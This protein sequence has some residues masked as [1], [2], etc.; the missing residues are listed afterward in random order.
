MAKTSSAKSN[1]RIRKGAVINAPVTPAKPKMTSGGRALWKGSIN[2]G[3]VCV[4]VA[5]YSSVRDFKFSGKLFRSGDLSP[6]NYKKIAETDGKEVTADQ[7][8]KGY[9]FI[10]DKG[11]TRI[12]TLN[13]QELASI[14]LPSL[15]NIDID[16]FVSAKEVDNILLAKSYFIRADKGGA[17][18][19]AIIFAALRKSG[20][21]GIAKVALRNREYLAVVRPN[22]SHP[23]QNLLQLDVLHFAPEMVSPDF[24]DGADLK[25]VSKDELTFATMLV[26]QMTRTF[27]LENYTN[28]YVDAMGELIAKK[29][30]GTLTTTPTEAPVAREVPDIL[31]VLRRS[32]AQKA[33]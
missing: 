4:P 30:A 19:Y 14:N 26:D 11:E 5:I 15:R 20:K 23:G 32:V 9:D 29:A 1:V 28:R 8:V 16:A 12:V 27:E 2:F 10:D 18:G 13:D 22:T 25:M 17:K 24:I 33:A 7:I 3:L 6:I 31:D 21:V